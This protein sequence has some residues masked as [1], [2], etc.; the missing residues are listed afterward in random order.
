[1][2]ALPLGREGALSPDRRELLSVFESGDGKGFI[3]LITDYWY[4]AP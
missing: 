4:Q 2:I 1:V 3:E